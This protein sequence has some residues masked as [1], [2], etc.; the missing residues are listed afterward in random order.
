MNEYIDDTIEYPTAVIEALKYFKKNYKFKSDTVRF[1]EHM[2][3]RLAGIR[4]LRDTLCREYGVPRVSVY[5]ERILPNPSPG[6]S[7]HCCYDVKLGCIRMIGKLSILT[8]LHEFS[9]HLQRGG[10]EEEARRWSINLFKRVYP[11]AFERLNVRDGYFMTE[12]KE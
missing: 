9:H 6:I 7:C 10:T 11:R 2:R 4:Q 12:R 3:R 8:F 1:E 5:A